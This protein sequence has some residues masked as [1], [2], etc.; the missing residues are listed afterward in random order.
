M[1]LTVNFFCIPYYT[2][3]KILFCRY[4]VN[5]RTENLKLTTFFIQNG[6]SILLFRGEGNKRPNIRMTTELII[7]SITKNTMTILNGKCFGS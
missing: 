4:V 5:N 2:I 1:F 6:T 7:I 3:V